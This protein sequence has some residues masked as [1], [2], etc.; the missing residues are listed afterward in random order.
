[1]RKNE[2][3][4]VAEKRIRLGVGV[5]WCRECSGEAPGHIREYER[6]AEAICGQCFFKD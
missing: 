3:V 4:E 5:Y 2:V 1:M 6:Y